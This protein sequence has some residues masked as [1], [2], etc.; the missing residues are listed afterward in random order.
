MSKNR[1]VFFAHFDVNNLIQDYVVY[2][3]KEL[4]KIANNIIFVSDSDIDEKQLEKISDI[5]THSIVGRHGEYDFGSYKKGYLY[6]CD[7]NG[8]NNTDYL[9]FAND[10]CYAPIT[11]FEKMFESMDEKKLDFWGI[12]ANKDSYWGNILHVQSYFLTFS[13]DVFLSDTFKNFINNICHQNSKKDVVT[14]YECGLTHILENAGFKWGVY[15]ERSKL[16]WCSLVLKYKDLISKE[17]CPVLK[18]GLVLNRIKQVYDKKGLKVFIQQNTNYQY[19]LIE[20]DYD[21]NS[22]KASFVSSLLTTIY[23]Y[24]VSLLISIK[25]VFDGDI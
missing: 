10:S 23:R 20:N 9:I 19:S 21:M 1:T 16:V 7:T 25:Q 14:K 12:T 2:Y 24:I 13:S 3:L 18:R 17:N 22:T 6:L 4:S 11:S 15:C 5:V 8:L